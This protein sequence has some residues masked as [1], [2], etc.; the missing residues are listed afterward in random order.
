MEILKDH[1]AGRLVG[2]FCN[3]DMKEGG[4]S[5]M[6]DQVRLLPPIRCAED[7][8]KPLFV[9][10][11]MYHEDILDAIRSDPALKNIPTLSFA[12]HF[13]ALDQINNYNICFGG[14]GYRASRQQ[15]Y[16]EFFDY[17]ANE[18]SCHRDDFRQKLRKTLD[19]LSDDVSRQIVVGRLNFF[20]TGTCDYLADTEVTS[21]RK[22]Y[23][24]AAFSVS[25]NE[26]YIDCGAYIGDTV[27]LFLQKTHGKYKKIIAIEPISAC[28]SKLEDFI[29]T[30][31]LKNA[32]ALQGLVGSAD[33]DGQD[34]ARFVSL[35]RFYSERPTLIKMDIEGAELEA[36]KGA[37][38]VISE[39]SPKLAV[40]L[41]H[42]PEDIF[43][44]IDY[45]HSINGSYKFMIRQHLGL[46]F[47]MVLYAWK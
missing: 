39:Q 44:I 28:F 38:R 2:A 21:W 46:M 42:K 19:L 36:L 4:E 30:R 26:T 35:D 9:I 37:E 3:S 33:R 5:A 34:G 18:F 7:V 1:G 12:D 41:Y 17:Y 14:K 40:C 6:V 16:W 47:D 43:E 32:V 24:G 23:F 11:S 10:A 31:D 25:D 45:L 22:E 29:R 8:P 20:L 27:D 13:S 15:M